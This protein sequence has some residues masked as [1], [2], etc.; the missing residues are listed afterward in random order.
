MKLMKTTRKK[1]KLETRGVCGI[2]QSASSVVFRQ[3]HHRTGCASSQA[4]VGAGLQSLEQQGGLGPCLIR[5]PNRRCSG[6]GD[7]LGFVSTTLCL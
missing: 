4:G 3:N 6:F 2:L 5:K 1:G 7:I